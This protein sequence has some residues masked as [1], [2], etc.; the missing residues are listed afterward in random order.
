MYRKAGNKV[1]F[2]A[3]TNARNDYEMNLAA[4]IRK[5]FASILLKQKSLFEGFCFN[6]S[7]IS[8]INLLNLAM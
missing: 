1:I 5:N 2:P 6:L 7:S 4:R 3:N 8:F